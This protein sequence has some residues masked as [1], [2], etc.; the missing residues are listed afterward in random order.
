MYY[1]A[2]TADQ[3]MII[4]PSES[5]QFERELFF[6]TPKG[7]RKIIGFSNYCRG[8][9]TG[10]KIGVIISK[11]D[12]SELEY[13]RKEMEKMNRLSTIAAIASAV[14]HE[15]RNPLA[16]I[17]IMAQSIEEETRDNIEQQ[18]CVQ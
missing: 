14:A 15:V 8:D 5:D 6:A 12:I 3:F 4:F 13:V 1:E 9:T 11:E 16:G 17:K 2:D 7:K 10:K 18:E